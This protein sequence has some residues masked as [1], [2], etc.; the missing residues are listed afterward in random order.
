MSD[1]KKVLILD[2]EED[3]RE[4][5]DMALEEVDCKCIMSSTIK[6]SSS[7][8]AREKVDLVFI[9]LAV[10]DGSGVELVQE[11][12]DNYNTPPKMV[13]YSGYLAVAGDDPVLNKIDA[14]IEK[15]C[16]NE[17]IVSTVKKLLAS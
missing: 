2:D 4:L 1:P 13:V 3:I 14:L 16:S 15:P 11:I 12:V 17:E 9:D 7:I 6:E 8:L 10:A 5:L